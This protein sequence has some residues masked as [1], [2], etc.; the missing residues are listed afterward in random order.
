MGTPS[1]PDFLA[2]Y[3]PQAPS[4]TTWWQNAA[5]FFLGKVVFRAVQSSS[6]T[7]L[8]SS[9]AVTKIAYDN[10]LEDPWS[11]WNASNHN[12]TPPGIATGLYQITVGV[13]VAAPGAS[14]VVVSPYAQGPVGVL[15]NTQLAAVTTSNQVCGGEGTTVAW[16]TG[17]QDAVSGAGSVQ[18]TASNVSTN[19]IAGQNSWLEIVWL[20]GL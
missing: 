19:I 5:T 11:G 2:G 15:G 18:N 4:F 3:S 8:P 12:W 6:A 20:L 1:V 16:L 17:G 14:D 13:I 10:V 7:T 9:G